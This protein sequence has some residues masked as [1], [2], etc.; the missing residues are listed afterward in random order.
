MPDDRNPKNG[1]RRRPGTGTDAASQIE[2]SIRQAFLRH[3]SEQQR[4][5]AVMPIAV[6]RVADRGAGREPPR[7]VRQQQHMGDHDK[8]E[9][10][11]Q[12]SDLRP[13]GSGPR[14]PR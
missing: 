2:D 10:E 5:F 12:G 14:T 8:L 3:M 9:R 11:V 13:R 7:K 4:Q 6:R 1:R